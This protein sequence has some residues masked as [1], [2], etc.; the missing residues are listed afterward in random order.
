MIRQAISCD[1]CGTEMQHAHHWFVAYNRGGELRVS[2]WNAETRMRSGAR[3]LCGQKCLH[4]LVDDFMAR[5]LAVGS[6]PVVSEDLRMDAK[7]TARPPAR[8]DGSLTRLAGHCVAEATIS[9]ASN[10][11]SGEFES[12][13]RLIP[14]AETGR[15]QAGEAVEELP[16]YASRAWRSQAWKREQEREQREASSSAGARRRSIA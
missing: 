8:L 2:G 9:R 11:V 7:R 6:E 14:P 1:I 5:T 16:A 13:S 15:L 4:K 3:H 12:S 10:H